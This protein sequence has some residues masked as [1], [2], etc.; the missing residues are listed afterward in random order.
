[1]GQ[2]ITVTEK[3]IH[4]PGFAR[5]EIDRSLTGMGH[6]RYRAG[7]EI[8]G[9]R[10]PDELARRLIA[11]GSVDAVHVYSNEITID[12]RKGFDDA[13][14]KEIIEHLFLYYGEGSGDAVE[15]QG[16]TPTAS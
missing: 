6:E 9:H 15:Q 2:P 10:P 1:M 8:T 7:D 13:G 5:F 4:K 3:P 16:V 14:L 11:T 12:I